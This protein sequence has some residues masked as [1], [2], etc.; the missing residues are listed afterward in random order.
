MPPV[1]YLDVYFLINLTMDYVILWTVAKLGRFRVSA[2]RLLAGALVGSVFSALGITGLV[3]IWGPESLYWKVIVS[4]VMTLVTFM[5]LGWI[6]ALYGIG[7]LYLVTFLIGGAIVGA[8]S[9]FSSSFYRLGAIRGVSSFLVDVKYPWLVAGI[10]A[11]WFF[12]RLGIPFLQKNVFQ[13]L[14][15][16]PI[17]LRFGKQAFPTYALVDTGN[18]LKDPLTQKPVMIVEYDLLGPILPE[19]V[20]RLFETDGEPDAQKIA[21]ILG[22]TSLAS[23]VR[24]IPFSSIGKPQ[25]LLLGLR[26]DEVVV[27]HDRRPIKIR[28]VI[29]G[30]YRKKLSP[31]GEYR[32]LLH[33][34]I[35][36]L[37]MGA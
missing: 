37:A 32:A 18:N 36:E 8:I 10:I 9:M 11:A 31:S 33:P 19:E 5:P 3:P 25:G 30:V 28:G 24:L 4:A 2:T 12:A 22:Q 6:Q 23:R 35:L 20:R 27:V 21:A 13:S 34:Q 29:I 15:R 26:P 14:F 7:Y 16:V 1:V 17:I